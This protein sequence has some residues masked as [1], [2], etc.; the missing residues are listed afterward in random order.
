MFLDLKRIFITENAA[1]P[2]EC[3]LDLSDLQF[4]GGYPLIKPVIAKGKV[5]NRAGVVY[6]R[7]KLSAV[8]SAPCDRC[9]ENAEKPLEIEVDRVIVESLS[10]E[11]T[12]E[13]IIAEGM[14]LDLDE[15]LT[16]EVV[17]AV[18]QKHLCKETCFGRCFK[19]GKNLNEGECS[20]EKREIDPRLLALKD[21]LN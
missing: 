14:K 11:D 8:Y 18:P 3:E 7:V 21:L 5:E 17:F 20:C 12:G 19:C 6:L 10:G 4:A 1:L 2:I 9:G 15:T 13:Y 16:S